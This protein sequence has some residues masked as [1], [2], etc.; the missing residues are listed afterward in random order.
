MK[1]RNKITKERLELKEQVRCKAA[2][3]EHF[4]IPA[5]SLAVILQ[6][7]Q[8]RQLTRYARS[9]GCQGQ[10]FSA[11]LRFSQKNQILTMKHKTQSDELQKPLR[12]LR[13]LRGEKTKK[14]WN[15]SKK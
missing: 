14:F 9:V 10:S 8:F 11:P 1:N 2:K 7:C 15:N 3:P 12:D 5:S 6:F 4:R 13:V